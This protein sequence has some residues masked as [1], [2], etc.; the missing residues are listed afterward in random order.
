MRRRA[1]LDPHNIGGHRTDFTVYT[2]AGAAFFD[3]REPY[4]VTNPRGWHYLYP[5]LFALLVAP[6][7]ALPT[8]WQG[9]T[10]FLLSLLM[11]AGC[12]SECQKIVQRMQE[13]VDGSQPPDRRNFPGWIVVATALALLFPF[14]DTLQRGQVGIAVLWPL[15]IG[16]R[17]ISETQRTFWWFWGGALLALPVVM[18]VTPALPVSI[19]LL[20]TFIAAVR[21][22]RSSIALRRF[23][24]CV[25]GFMIGMI[26]FLLL[27]PTIL[28]GWED[29]I[30][31]LETWY[32]GVAINER[33]GMTKNFDPHSV[34]NQSLD[35]AVY[36][37]GNWFAYT[38]TGGPDDQ[39]TSL[40]T[41][42]PTRFPMD[43]PIVRTI[44][45]VPRVLL[46]LLLIVVAIRWHWKTEGAGQVTVF[47]LACAMSL[48]LSPISWG[49]HFV[50]LLP[51][52]L[53][54]PWA[55]YE[56]HRSVAR[57]LAISAAML[58]LVHY[59]TLEF[60]G[61]IAG[62]LG[63]LGIGITIWCTVAGI[64][65]LRIKPVHTPSLIIRKAQS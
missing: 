48:P 38:F 56:T 23:L 8:S 11:G 63:V 59:S 64:Y 25:S 31:H 46:A 65:L 16:F 44:L 5:P 2:E 18:K 28:I 61:G 41:A 32:T 7:H 1:D 43:A 54:L 42:P 39:G 3:G 37:L 19:L 15:L 22:E 21:K 9:V 35:N 34:R 45:V 50:M 62:R 24:H 36:R 26:F 12:I 49:H 6:L 17:L 60:A 33:L 40:P 14:L 58:S 52:M 53:F 13:A 20:Q 57:W 27:V 47:G 30:R 55:L 4:A 51:G 10:W 29:N